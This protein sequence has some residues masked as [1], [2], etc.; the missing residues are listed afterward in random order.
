MPLHRPFLPQ[1]FLHW[2]D[3][4]ATSG[5]D[6]MRIVSWRRTLTLQGTSFADFEREVLPL[7]NGQMTTEDICDKV[8]DIFAKADVEAALDMLAAQGIV[9]EA[10]EHTKGSGFRDTHMGWLGET[11]PDGRAAQ[12]YISK[13]HVVVFGAGQHGA[14]V[15]RSLAASGIS[16][17]S[18]SHSRM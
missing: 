5:Q 9:V 14:V 16:A 12:E 15:A 3:T 11:A 13:A 6:V 2:T 18:R 10:D 8:S 7:L 4:S 1:C 17:V